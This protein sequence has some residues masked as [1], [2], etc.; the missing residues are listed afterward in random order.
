[1]EIPVHSSNLG[2]MDDQDLDLSLKAANMKLESTS[3]PGSYTNL[4]LI[5]VFVYG[6][7]S[8]CPF[9][10]SLSLNDLLVQ[11]FSRLE[12]KYT[13]LIPGYLS[14]PVAIK[15][16]KMFKRTLYTSQFYYFMIPMIGSILGI[17]ICAAYWDDS[18]IF[19]MFL[20]NF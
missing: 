1:M 9:S 20:L 2:I 7:L 18:T 12:I 19:G 10:I 15:V 5:Y 4:S 13:L 14:L 6:L 17:L 8:L 16:S 11:K 3:K